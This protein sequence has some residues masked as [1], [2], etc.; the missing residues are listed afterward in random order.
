MWAGSRWAVFAA[1]S[2]PTACAF[3][4]VPRPLALLVATVSVHRSDNAKECNKARI[5]VL[6][7]QSELIDEVI[8]EAR[9]NLES[10][11]QDSGAYAE[12]LVNLITQGLLKVAEDDCLIR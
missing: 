12:L 9:G 1:F 2:Q 10:V 4:R 7:R 3:V 8:E 5:A 6:K 11:T